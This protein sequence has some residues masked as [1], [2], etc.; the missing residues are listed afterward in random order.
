M[1]PVG[2]GYVARHAV[3]TPGNPQLQDTHFPRLPAGVPHRTPRP[4]SAAEAAFLAIGDGAALWLTE[5]ATASGDRIR[6]KTAEAVAL[7]RLHSAAVVDRALGQ[8]AT[9]G[10]FVEGT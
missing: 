8:A 4:R 3:T 7:T 9:A 6:A 5:A 1:N 2:G 10:R